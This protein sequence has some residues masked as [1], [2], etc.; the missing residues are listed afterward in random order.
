MG[1]LKDEAVLQ[2]SNWLPSQHGQPVGSP[3]GSDLKASL[4]KCVQNSAHGQGMIVQPIIQLA[5]LLM[6]GTGDKRGHYMPDGE[7]SELLIV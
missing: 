2:A 4:L 5:T 1:A 7:E 3:S 6:E